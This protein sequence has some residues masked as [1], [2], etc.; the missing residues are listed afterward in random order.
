MEAQETPDNSNTQNTPDNV[1]VIEQENAT[2][3]IT[4]DKGEGG[5]QKTAATGVIHIAEIEAKTLLIK[6]EK[7]EEVGREEVVK[8]IH[9]AETDAREFMAE[10]EM[11]EPIK[12][13][14]QDAKTFGNFWLK[15]LND[16]VFNFASGL[17]YHLLTAMFPIVIALLI[18]IGFISG[19]L[20]PHAQTDLINHLNAF[21]PTVLSSQNVLAPA[22]NLIRKDAGFLGILAIFVAL[23][24]GSRLFIT[25]EDFFDVIYHT[26]A[27]SFLR[28][29]LM[30][31]GMLL[32]FIV[33]IPVMLLAS[34]ISQ[35]ISGFFTGLIASWLL[36]EAIYM[37]VPNQHISLR[38]SW[39]GAVVA[40]LALQLYIAIFPLYA[41][42]F[43]GSYTG[44]AGFAVILLIFF[45][46]FAIILL[47]GAE[48]NAYYAEDIRGTPTNIAGLVHRAT[49]DIDKAKLTELAQRKA[50]RKA[51]KN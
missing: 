13:V 6:T 19:G 34:S 50:A 4:T 46:Y 25:L 20:S 8:I 5:G 14:V 24:S 11:H 32:L 30:A 22:L 31:I 36:F 44:N 49:L 40:A 10:A 2:L 38:N 17:A 23:L 48:V 26:Q 29:N 9:I 51:L 33:L 1:Q 12:E 47:L 7:E 37:F 15:F 42:H 43:L 45:Y 27:R 21:F 39:Q 35:G 16:W 3:L 18:T 41:R 28:Q